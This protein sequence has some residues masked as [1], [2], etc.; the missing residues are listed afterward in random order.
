MPT[1][2][3]N[4]AKFVKLPEAVCT[5]GVIGIQVVVVHAESSCPNAMVL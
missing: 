4:E 1:E 3:Q 2:A 5:G